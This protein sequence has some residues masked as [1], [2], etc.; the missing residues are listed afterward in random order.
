MGAGRTGLAIG[1]AWLSVAGP[2][3]A[4][5]S[6]ESS[7]SSEV[8][9]RLG[10]ATLRPLLAL[11]IRGEFRQGPMQRGGPVYASSALQDD[12][13]N[14]ALPVTSPELA[15]DSSLWRIAER[16]RLGLAVSYRQA[17]AVVEL[18]DARAFGSLPERGASVGGA[19]LM[20]SLAYL[21]FRSQG[22]DPLLRFRLGRQRVA[23]GDG[24]LLGRNAWQPRGG[25]L[26]AARLRLRFG[27]RV[28]AE[29]LAALLSFPGPLGMDFEAPVVDAAEPVAVTGSGAQ[30]VGLR[31]AVP[32]RAWL[33]VE[34]VGLGRVVRAPV[35][36]SLHRGDT[37]TV[38]LRLHGSQGGFEY[39]GE[40]ALQL[41]RVAGY[42]ANRNIVALASAA[43]ASWQTSLPGKLRFDVFGAYA[44]GDP[45]NG[46]G[47]RFER[48]DPILPDVHKHHGLMD[49]YSWSN[50]IE[51]GL[52]L[53]ALVLRGTSVDVHYA[54]VGLAEPN[55]RWSLGSL[56]PVGAAANNSSRELGHE[57]DVALR[58]RLFQAWSIGA[59][60]GAFFLGKG[61]QAIMQSV[62]RS[63]R[64]LM[65]YSYFQSQLQLP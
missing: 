46:S 54:F 62:G 28:R 11:R 49:M 17:A 53:G 35:P 58:Y 4:Q 22:K 63:D 16:A 2:V 65:H 15:A 19:A 43:R 8:V 64:R 32:L 14:A 42:G 1:L 59:G 45:S 6:E 13:P 50:L 41:G 21:D 9:Y 60:Y 5:A 36:S 12:A 7:A 33:E 61:G 51:G 29:V 20:P 52:G 24:R 55:D 25:A 56:A 31:L 57:L 40:L 39:A 34:A 44:S 3:G 26:D 23:W 38:D 30:L 10:G 37:Y 47:E 27:D 18:Q 48:F